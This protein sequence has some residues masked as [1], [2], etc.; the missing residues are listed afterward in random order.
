LTPVEGR[1]VVKKGMRKYILHV[2]VP[3]MAEHE[4]FDSNSLFKQ[5]LGKAHAMQPEEPDVMFGET[6]FQV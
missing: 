3:G 1:D 6:L 2:A 4:E 5:F